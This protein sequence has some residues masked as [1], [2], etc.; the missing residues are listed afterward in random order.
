MVIYV[1]CND[2]QAST[3]IVILI[4]ISFTQYINLQSYRMQG[5]NFSFEVC[6]GENKGRFHPNVN[7]GLF[8]QTSFRHI[9]LINLKTRSNEVFLFDVEHMLCAVSS[10]GDMQGHRQ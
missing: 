4:F 3:F 1:Q 9:L 6:W 7:H 2:F 10:S 5:F 8:F